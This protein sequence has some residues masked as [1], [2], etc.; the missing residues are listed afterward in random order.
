MGY[1]LERHGVFKGKRQGLVESGPVGMSEGIKARAAADKLLDYKAHYQADAEAI[2][3]PEE[4]T[5]L[6]HTSEHRRLA[7]LVRLLR[8]QPGE[9]LLDCGCGSGWLAALSRAV[10]A[11]VWAMDIAPTGVAAARGRFP[12]AAYFQ[13]GDV[14]HLPFAD[15]SFDAL[16]LSEVVEH[17]E[18]IEAAFAEV[19][20][21]LRPGGRVLVSVPYHETIVQHLCIHCNRFTPANAH[22]HQFDEKKL[23][24]YLVG[25]GLEVRQ[26]LLLTNK[27]LELVGFPRWS[28]RWPHW[29]W[30]GV[31]WL[32]NKLTGKP[33]FLCVL[34]ART[35]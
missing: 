2:V 8:L 19:Q 4:L 5:P 32:F 23:A 20:R 27:L 12:E 28:R 25:Q 13:V 6:R 7:S 17:L 14:Y 10:G 9:K 24:S 16:V 31:D 34:A 21:V 11:R 18:D 1:L 15:A 33:A 29:S 30:R 35:D 22:L 26:I 3:D